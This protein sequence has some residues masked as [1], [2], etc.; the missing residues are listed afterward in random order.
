VI[1][2]DENKGGKSLVKK[3]ALKTAGGKPGPDKG[4][5]REKRKSGHLNKR[6]TTRPLTLTLCAF[7]CSIGRTNPF[8]GVQIQVCECYGAWNTISKLLS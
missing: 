2:D 1:L 5:V 4:C 6:W 8:K 3:F 7:N